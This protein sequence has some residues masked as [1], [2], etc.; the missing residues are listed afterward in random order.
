MGAEKNFLAGG[1]GQKM[2]CNGFRPMRG[3]EVCDAALPGESVGR[4][5]AGRPA[6]KNE[7]RRRVNPMTFEDLKALD[8]AYIMHT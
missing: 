4:T 3:P 6:R 5:F 8:D 1:A 7:K 2:D